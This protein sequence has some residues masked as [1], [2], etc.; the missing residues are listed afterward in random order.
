MK[1]AVYTMVVLGLSFSVLCCDDV[2][3]EADDTHEPGDTGQNDQDSAPSCKE[4]T[5]HWCELCFSD[6]VDNCHQEL[7]VG[8]C[9]LDCNPSA[10]FLDCVMTAETCVKANK[11]RTQYAESPFGD[12]SSTCDDLCALCDRCYSTYPAFSESDCG[13]D[14][15]FDLD[16]CQSACEADETMKQGLSALSKPIAEFTCCEFDVLF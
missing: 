5:A 13:G 1:F 12:I 8:M 15:E 4:V 9:G 7:E 11:C 10:N 2:D 16:S 6:D 3:V 14:E